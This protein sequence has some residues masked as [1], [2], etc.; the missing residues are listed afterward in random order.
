MFVFLC[1]RFDVISLAE[2]IEP[3]SKFLF[4]GIHPGASIFRAEMLGILLAK[5]RDTLARLRQCWCLC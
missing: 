2:E 3:V 1:K 5:D 4:L